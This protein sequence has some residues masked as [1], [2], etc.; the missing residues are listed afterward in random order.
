MEN[1][2]ANNG[3]MHVL[4]AQFEVHNNWHEFNILKLLLKD[5]VSGYRR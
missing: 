5:I 1:N 4:L 2:L 3:T